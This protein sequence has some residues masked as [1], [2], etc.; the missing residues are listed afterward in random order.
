MYCEDLGDMLQILEPSNSIFK[1]YRR[2]IE[3]ALTKN[4][5][6]TMV[7]LMRKKFT[8]QAFQELRDYEA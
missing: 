8:D 7:K 1:L 4:I 3:I 5:T 6:N 2:I